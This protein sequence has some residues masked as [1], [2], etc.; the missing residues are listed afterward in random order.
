M[1]RVD[2]LS[3]TEDLFWHARMRI[4]ASLPRRLDGDLL[5]AV[6]IG[7]NAYLTLMSL[8]EAPRNE[9]RMSDLADATALS[10]SRMT[11]LVGELQSRG[12]LSNMAAQFEDRRQLS[13][14][15][16]APS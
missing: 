8:S 16:T 14:T 9:L 12:L 13:G 3:A 7:A 5:Q 4:V 6:G 11:R 10:S 2:S 15:E 1:S